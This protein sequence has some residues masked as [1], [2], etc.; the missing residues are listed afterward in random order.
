MLAESSL[1][2]LAD[3]STRQKVIVNAHAIVAGTI[4]SVTPGFFFGEPGSLI[5]LDNL[6]KIKADAL[7]DG[8]RESLYLRL[9]YAQFVIGG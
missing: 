1:E 2:P 9:P 4:R 3:T 8:L 6:D 5:E 7:Y